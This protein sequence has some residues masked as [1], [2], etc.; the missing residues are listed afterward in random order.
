M[1]TFWW[2]IT[3]G[4]K[5]PHMSPIVVKL[6]RN[7]G[8]KLRENQA[9]LVVPLNVNKPQIRN[10]MEQLYKVRARQ[11]CAWACARARA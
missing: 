4:G 11:A 1:K 9:A 3:Q 2:R 7:S 8:S 5:V 6:M 10:Y